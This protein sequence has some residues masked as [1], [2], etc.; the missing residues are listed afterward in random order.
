MF[1]VISSIS[2]P[3]QCEWPE[4]TED[5]LRNAR[6]T[7]FLDSKLR[8]SVDDCDGIIFDSLSKQHLNKD[9][10]RIKSKSR[11]TDPALVRVERKGLKYP[12]LYIFHVY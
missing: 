2:I 6:V 4:W 7:V 3:Q 5:D 11:I 8:T 1:V 10:V 12:V 9:N